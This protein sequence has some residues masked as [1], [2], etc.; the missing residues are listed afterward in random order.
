MREK[1]VVGFGDEASRRATTRTMNAFIQCATSP[2]PGGADVTVT[3]RRG[4]IVVPEV[5]VDTGE[6][7]IHVR[8]DAGPR[9]GESVMVGKRHV[10]VAKRRYDNYGRLQVMD[11][12]TGAWVAME[13]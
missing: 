11:A 12:D 6:V 3:T 5:E 1:A 8:K 2:A 4:Y 13:Q 7:I 10:K 9:V